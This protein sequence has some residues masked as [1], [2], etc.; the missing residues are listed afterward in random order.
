MLVQAA[1]PLAGLERLLHP[2]AA[3]GHPDQGGQRQAAPRV[4]AA[5]LGPLPGAD[6]QPARRRD[7]LG[8]PRSAG[9]LAW[10]SSAVTQPAGT[11][12]SSALQHHPDQ[13]DHDL[14]LEY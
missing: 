4:P 1:Q 3:P 8:Q 10:T 7:V 14:R 9:L 13:S 12:A 2:P 5:A 11:P 6:A